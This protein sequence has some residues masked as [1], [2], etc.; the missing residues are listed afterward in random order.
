MSSITES[1]MSVSRLRTGQDFLSDLKRTPRS[2]YVDGEK[3]SNPSEH[4]A[5]RAG[6]RSIARLFEFAAAQENREAMTYPSPDTGAPVW[7]C[8]QIPHT[9]TDLRAKRIAAEK[10]AELSFGLMGRTPDHV[11]DFFA[12]LPPKARRFGKLRGDVPQFHALSRL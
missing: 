5:F 1:N 6:A 2:I 4:P 8:W 9:H 3:L 10:W 11:A 12:G 7:R